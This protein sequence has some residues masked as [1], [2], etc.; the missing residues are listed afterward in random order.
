MAPL[1]EYIPVKRTERG[2]RQNWEKYFIGLV[3]V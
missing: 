2:V 3:H 1:E